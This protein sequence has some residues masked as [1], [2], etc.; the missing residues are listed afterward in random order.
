M[1]DSRRGAFGVDREDGLAAGPL[2]HGDAGL[3]AD[4]E[5]G[6]GAAGPA[7]ADDDVVEDDALAEADLVVVLVAGVDR[8]GLVLLAEDLVAVVGEEVAA[9]DDADEPT[10]DVDATG[11]TSM[12]DL[13]DARIAPAR[14]S[15]SCRKGMPSLMTSRAVEVGL[16]GAGEHACGPAG[17]R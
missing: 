16:G 7:A 12:P 6:E 11:R 15:V 5:V 4:V 9:A 10:V 8:H 14:V 2:E 13:A 17:C 3:A 1:S